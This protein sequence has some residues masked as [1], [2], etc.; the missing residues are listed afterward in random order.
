MMTPVAVMIIVPM[1]T[2]WVIVVMVVMGLYDVAGITGYHLRKRGNRCS[3]RNVGNG[4]G[5]KSY[6]RNGE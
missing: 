6:G 3:F 2:V 4:N 1:P 5:S